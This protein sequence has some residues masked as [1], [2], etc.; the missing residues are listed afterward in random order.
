MRDAITGEFLHWYMVDDEGQYWSND[1]HRFKRG[2][3][4][5]LGAHV[6]AHGR[7]EADRLLEMA[8]DQDVGLIYAHTDSVWTVE[9]LRGTT[10]FPRADR[11]G[12]I[13]QERHRDVVFWQG[14]RWVGDRLDAMTPGQPIPGTRLYRAFDA[15]EVQAEARHLAMFDAI[16]DGSL[17]RTQGSRHAAH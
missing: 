6:L 3:Y 2:R 17:T 11:P 7:R 13:T 1:R 8:T 4:H 5:A 12:G 16:S 15:P 14:A 9:P 10:G